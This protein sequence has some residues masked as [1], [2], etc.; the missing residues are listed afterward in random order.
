[1]FLTHFL[2]CLI[3][4]SFSIAVILLTKK[5]FQRNLSARWHYNIWYLLFVALLIPFIPKPLLSFGSAFPLDALHSGNWLGGLEAIAESPAQEKANWLNDFA[6][7]VDRATPAYLD[8]LV[9]IIWVAGML[10]FTVPAIHAVLKMEKIKKSTSRIQNPDLL[11]LLDECKQRIQL[12]GELIVGESPLVQSPMMF[13]LRRTYI[14][15]PLGFQEWLSQNEIRYVLLHELS[16]SKNK[17]NLSNF[18][19]VLF[20]LLYWFSPLVWIAFR[21][22]RVDREIACD[23]DVLQTLDE[24]SHVEYGHTIIHFVGKVSKQKRFV[25]ESE[26]GSSKE[27]LK[28]RIQKI[29]TFQMDSTQLRT[30]SIAVFILAGA[31]VISQ[32]PLV[33]AIASDNM[34][35]PFHGDN[36]DYEDLASFFA[37]YD[38]SFVMYDQKADRYSIYNKQQSESRVSPDSTYK[39]YSALFALESHVITNDHSTLAWS[40][41]PSPYAEWNRD[42]TLN[43][44]M[45]SSVN[46]YFQELD[47][48][49]GI[50]HLQAYLSK[51]GYGNENVSGG[52]D[53]FW[54][55]SSLKISPVE[56]VLLLRSFYFNQFGFQKPNIQTVKNAIALEEKDG[57]LLS[58]KTGTGAVNHKE[59]NGW[60]VGYVETKGNTYFFATNIQGKEHSSGSKAAEI[61]LSILKEKGIYESPRRVNR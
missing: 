54:M 44:A 33:T 21:E 20:Q 5:I 53:S 42:Q 57:A 27:Q 47:Q 37:G 35:Y 25:L 3:V 31:I 6:V 58:G 56:Q 40:G 55:E 45:K 36:A 26:I 32:I 49:T 59:T 48:A 60:F 7:S 29:A 30:K 51:I 23:S 10:L 1:M 2:T 34:S 15:F 4:S 46:W 16:H 61:T 38:G 22:M 52:V 13:G 18:L 9:V 8:H 17:D 41:V 43:T 24:R 19:I 50:D 28:R 14:V 39:I 11:R 12:S